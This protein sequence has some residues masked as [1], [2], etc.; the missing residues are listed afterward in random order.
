MDS[1]SLEQLNR[2][3]RRNNFTLNDIEY[4]I[5]TNQRTYFHLNDRREIMSTM[6]LKNIFSCLPDLDFWSIQKGIVVAVRYVENISDHFIYT[7]EDGATFQGRSRNPAEHKRRR[8]LLQYQ[9]GNYNSSVPKK[10]SLQDLC[11]ML[12]DAPLAFSIIEL[13]FSEDG[14]GI[15]FIFR[16]CNTEMSKLEGVPV[17]DMLN[18]SFYEVFPNADRKWIVP[19]ADVAINGNRRSFHKFSPEVQKNLYIQC[20]QP[21]PGYCACLLI[22]E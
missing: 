22:E 6:T 19:Y 16:Y 11:S 13:L 4:I 18:R 9:K 10:L 3:Y 17:E 1:R 8:R 15:D 21:I 7:M 14:R 2:I 5:H 12:D 20:F